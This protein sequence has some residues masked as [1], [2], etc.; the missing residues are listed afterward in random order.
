MSLHDF[1]IVCD[2]G[3]EPVS[4]LQQL[5]AGKI[6]IAGG[7]LQLLGRCFVVKEC[8]ADFKFNPAA[9]IFVLRLALAQQSVCLLNFRLDASTLEERDASCDSSRRWFVVAVVAPG[10]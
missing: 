10:L 2:A 1:K 6:E 9:Q 3:G 5:L 4:G 7:Y 8:G